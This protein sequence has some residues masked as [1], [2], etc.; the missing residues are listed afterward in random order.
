MQFV[1]CEF[2]HVAGIDV[3]VVVVVVYSIQMMRQ[4]ISPSP[5]SLLVDSGGYDE[6]D[7]ITIF[8]ALR[9]ARKWPAR[10]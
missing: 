10:P 9:E 3:I 8:F 6:V 2:I 1:Y 7:S 4:E 5:R